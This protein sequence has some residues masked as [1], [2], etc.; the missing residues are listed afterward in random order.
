MCINK[1]SHLQNMACFLNNQ[2]PACTVHMCYMPISPILL[3]CTEAEG[4]QPNKVRRENQIKIATTYISSRQVILIPYAM[5]KYL[6][7]ICID[8]YVQFSN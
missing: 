1:R 5:V 8:V 2:L 3:S 4:E 6:N 7:C